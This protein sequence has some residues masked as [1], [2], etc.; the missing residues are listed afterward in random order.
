MLLHSRQKIQ[1]VDFT[2]TI[3]PTVVQIRQDIGPSQDGKQVQRNRP[4]LQRGGGLRRIRVVHCASFR[5]L[6][7][8]RTAQA[9]ADQSQC[10]VDA[11]RLGQISAANQHQ[12]SQH[13]NPH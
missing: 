7:A 11:D 6:V 9:R 12:E 4:R 8:S 13:I 3:Q 2:R 5:G 10:E 1:V